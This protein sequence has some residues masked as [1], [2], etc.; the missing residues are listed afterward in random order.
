MGEWRYS[1]T[2][3]LTSALEWWSGV[4]VSGQLHTL[5]YRPIL[6]LSRELCIYVCK[7]VYPKVSGLSHNEINNNKNTRWEATQR[8]MAAKLTRLTHKIAIQLHL[9]AESCTI[10]SSRSRWQVRK[11]FGYTAI[12]VYEEIPLAPETQVSLLP[13]MHVE[14]SADVAWSTNEHLL[15]GMWKTTNTSRIVDYRDLNQV[16][17]ETRQIFGA[18]V[19]QSVYR[20]C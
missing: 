1:F 8:V 15:K 2:L 14:Q 20:L 10:C 16:P 3:S 7:R 11:L 18:G 12:C 5:R 6:R 9:V 19:A 4:E 13:F 17:F